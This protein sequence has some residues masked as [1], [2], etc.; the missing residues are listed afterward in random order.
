MEAISA[1]ALRPVEDTAHSAGKLY[2]LVGLIDYFKLGADPIR[3]LQ[4]RFRV[5][6]RQQH[7][8]LRL[9]SARTRT[10]SAI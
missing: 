5:A 3:A 4:G 1:Y 8:D 7:T 2:A 6:R 10:A 9:A